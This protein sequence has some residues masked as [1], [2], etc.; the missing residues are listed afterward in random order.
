[1]ADPLHLKNLAHSRE[2]WNAWRRENP[3]IVPDLEGITRGEGDLPGTPWGESF[4]H[5]A[6]EGEGSSDIAPEVLDLRGAR[7]LGADLKSA[8]LRNV[9]LAGADLRGAHLD[10]ALLASVDLQGAVLVEASLTDTIANHAN[11]ADAVMDRIRAQK[12]DLH[13]SCFSRACL[14]GADF[15]AANLSAADLSHAELEGAN[16]SDTNLEDANLSGCSVYGASVWNTNLEN[17]KQSALIVSRTDEPLISVDNLEVAQ[18]VHLLLNQRR[19][20]GVIDSIT[21]KVVLILGR[22]TPERKAILDAIRERLRAFDYLPL[23]FDF[24]KPTNRDITETVSTLAHLA[25][26]VIAD[27]T[28]AKSIPQELMCIVP[29]L[30]SVPIQPLLL[31]SQQE[32]AMFEHFRHYPWVLDVFLYDNT[33]DL[34]SSFT[35]RVIAPAEARAAQQTS[36]RN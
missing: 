1:M 17:C 5:P 11:F 3:T 6:V 27:I 20:R 26:F 18:F 13:M 7:L 28:D 9:C 23:L 36:Q 29:N 4:F 33:E 34:L 35:E 21:S 22:F 12:S 24:D 2:F 15:R 32:Y 30:P 25:R 8:D 19:L 31:R 14:V 10:K 16:L